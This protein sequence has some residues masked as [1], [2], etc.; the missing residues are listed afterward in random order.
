[1][2]FTVLPFRFSMALKV[3]AKLTK[4]GG[5]VLVLWEVDTTMYLHNWL[6]IGDTARSTSCM[7]ST[8]LNIVASMRFMFNLEKSALTP[9]QTTVWL[10][11]E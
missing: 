2:Q 9:T 5:M 11:L 4:E 7:V 3:F 10:E 8:N 6:V 1:M